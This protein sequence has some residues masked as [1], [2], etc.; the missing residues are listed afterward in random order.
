MV[1]AAGLAAAMGVGRFAYTPLLPIMTHET[2]LSST[3]GAAIAT[4]N[5]A[6]Y[7]IGAVVV[8]AKPHWCSR[9]QAISIMAA[10]LCA[11]EVAM[12]LAS[13]PVWWSILRLLAGAASAGLF[14]CC[15]Q[16]LSR[17]GDRDNRGA[18]FMGLGFSGVGIGIAVTGVSVLVLSE[19]A[20]WKAMWLVL[21]AITTAL[22]LPLLLAS[23]RDRMPDIAESAA[24][25]ASGR[26]RQIPGW[27]LIVAVYFL[28]GVGYIV[29]GTFLVA[30]VVDNVGE[31]FGPIAWIV[32]GIAAAPGTIVWTTLGDRIGIRR[33]LAAAL[34]L[35]AVG[36]LIPAVADG[37]VAA[38]IAA[39]LF[40]GTFMG[41]TALAIKVGVELRGSNAAGPL[42]VAYGLGQMLG[43]LVVAPVLGSAFAAAFVVAAAV[44][45]AAA[46]LSVLVHVR[47]E[48]HLV[49]EAIR[50]V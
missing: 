46:V 3:A 8:S 31:R 43:P 25:D 42:T 12:V 7:L 9:P 19:F 27:T 5:Y 28:E 21:A 38:L 37:A 35:Q 33:A 20:S 36:A 45:L 14:V 30:S 32:A 13:D 2:G 29:V 40:G 50:F 4:A 16:R 10:T 44:L 23:F 39:A 34:A 6:G 15:V 26:A 17:A 18:L 49:R 24:N 22:L 11:S 48:R 47:H 41:I 1:I